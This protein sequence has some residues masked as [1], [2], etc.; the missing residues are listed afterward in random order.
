M[1]IASR[2]VP[3]V[4]LLLLVAGS[5]QGEDRP[6]P[7]RIRDANA[8]AA[9]GKHEEAISAWKSI[10]PDIP[11]D[12]PDLVRSVVSHLFGILDK[13]K[14]YEEMEDVLEKALEKRPRDEVS[15]GFLGVTKENMGKPAEALDL[16]R[17]VYLLWGLYESWSCDRIEDLLL[18]KGKDLSGTLSVF[19]SLSEEG[20][21]RAWLARVKLGKLAYLNE[22]DPEK[23]RSIL[24]P[25]TRK[26][27]HK[28]WEAW[29]LLGWIRVDH[30][31][32]L[33]LQAA[34]SYLCALR[35][36]PADLRCELMAAYIAD[37][38]ELDLRRHDVA[39]SI[40]SALA[41]V[42]GLAPASRAKYY[43][44]IAMQSYRSGDFDDAGAQ[45][46]QAIGLMP[47]NAEFRNN[48]GLIRMAQGKGAE[49]LICFK[50]SLSLDPK[51]VDAMENLG[52]YYWKRD[53]GKKARE[54]FL[55]GYSL[56][57]ERFPRAHAALEEARKAGR[58]TE[59]PRLEL[60]EK[61]ERYRLYRFQT[62]LRR[63]AD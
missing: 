27:G 59:L 47:G 55:E 15:M 29:K 61:K 31:K 62:Y 10:V 22:G 48:L 46:E 28:A 20:G 38:N 7:E 36:K 16:Y 54:Y 14:R 18:M 34:Q 45:L 2:W 1:G 44:Y 39:R 57:C 19:R 43:F 24:E 17:R 49:A 12:Q 9:A 41:S 32:V 6:L 58:T 42:E 23:A 5:A 13:L 50:K 3:A 30:D 60:A 63:F 21:E 35:I 56:A 4:L 37:V 11:A 52:V 8:L 26:W 25:I 33:D 51:Y 53:R 40:W